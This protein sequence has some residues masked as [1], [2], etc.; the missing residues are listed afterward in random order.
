[1]HDIE[2]ETAALQETR[3]PRF[4]FPRRCPRAIF[5]RQDGTRPFELTL[6]RDASNQRVRNPMRLQVLADFCG[7]V[8][9]REPARARL[10][11]ALVGKLLARAQL[12][13]QRLERRRRFRV[14]QRSARTLSSVGVSGRSGFIEPRD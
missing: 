9:A 4:L 3:A 5:A 13:E 14:R 8:L 6:R 12:V 2:G 7:A 10:G 1:L 11:V